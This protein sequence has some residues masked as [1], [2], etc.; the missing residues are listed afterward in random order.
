MHREE[1]P[2]FD[3]CELGC[4]ELLPRHLFLRPPPPRK[5][6]PIC[7]F[8]SEEE[9]LAATLNRLTE[10]ANVASASFLD[11]LGDL[12]SEGELGKESVPE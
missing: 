8:R 11:D 4:S 2:H 7:D 10:I 9:I 5:G 3:F 6:I 1:H 12:V